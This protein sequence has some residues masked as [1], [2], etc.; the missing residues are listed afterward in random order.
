VKYTEWEASVPAAL[1][2][3][4]LWRRHDY[5]LALYAA[6]LGWDDVRRLTAERASS[7]IADQRAR[8][9]GSVSANI[10][11]GYSRSSGADRV[12]FYGYALGS[13]RE[14]RDWYQKARRTLG[15]ATTRH[16]LKVLTS[17]VRLLTHSLPFERAATIPKEADAEAPRTC[18]VGD[19]WAA[20]NATRNTQ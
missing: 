1:R 18:S 9:L 16:R 17:V 8:S 15:P 20:V 19:P 12:R 11:E 10:A 3:D 6:D 4:L 14:S 7:A 13:A 2:D 5:R